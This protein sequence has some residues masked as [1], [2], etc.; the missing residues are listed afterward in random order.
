MYEYRA[1]LLRAVDGD[2]IDVQL[3][4]GL[5]IYQ[6]IKLRLAEINAPELSTEEGQAAKS[7]L[8]EMLPKT[9]WA[10]NIRTIKD[11][12]EKYGR[13]LAQVMFQDSNGEIIF[14]NN[15]MIRTGNA[16]PYHG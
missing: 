10:L 6:N 2:T 13:Y 16:V 3:D 5:N 12:K 14:A 9:P 8:I 7:A 4:L 15:E 1:T 11:R